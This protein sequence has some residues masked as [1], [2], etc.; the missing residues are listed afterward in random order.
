MT[1]DTLDQRSVALRPETH[2]ANAV[3]QLGL[4][5]VLITALRAWWSRPRLP[6]NLPDR[7]RADVGLPPEQ[8]RPHWIEQGYTTVDFDRFTR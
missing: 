1:Y 4:F 2:I 7:L 8:R 6:P 3:L 5:K